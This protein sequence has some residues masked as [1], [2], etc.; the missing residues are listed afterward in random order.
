[1]NNKPT[2][3]LVH[4]AEQCS[5]CSA[6]MN[7]CPKNA[8][9][10]KEDLYGFLF[11]VINEDLCVSCYKCVKICD[12]SNVHGVSFRKPIKGFAAAH[13]NADTIR[14]CASGG[15]ATAL[16]E[17]VINK[18]GYVYGCKL[19]DSFDAIHTCIH[20]ISELKSL[21]GSKYVQSNIGYVFRDVSDKLKSGDI[22][23]FVG[24]PCQIAGLYSY[25]GSTNT[26]NLITV[27]IICHGTPNNKL[28]K[29]FIRY[30]EKVYNSK[31]TKFV[32]RSKKYG[33][34]KSIQEIELGKEKGLKDKRYLTIED[35][36]FMKLFGDGSVL[37]KS[38]YNCKYARSERVSDM[39]IGDF[40]GYYYTKIPFNLRKGLSC[41]LVNSTK[42]LDILP[43]LYLNM[44]EVNISAIL[45]GNPNLNCPSKESPRWEFTMSNI[46][47]GKF[48]E[49]AIEYRNNSKL[50]RF[51]GKIKLHIPQRVID[52]VKFVVNKKK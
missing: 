9:T 33:W 30:L 3:N 28:L 5:G 15:V 22:V 44:Q 4:S 2:P 45:S 24:T 14:N 42:M 1:M 20:S 43:K 19:S 52:S 48:E 32:F 41:C 13:K 50:K 40:W 39:T 10:M 8:I 36:F 34:G 38:C 21:S 29:E 27:D 37:R 31:I 12:F 16:S 6:C 23:L 47:K 18:G 35:S 49:M 7:A 46:A 51:M 17:Y 26:D 11:P 25:L